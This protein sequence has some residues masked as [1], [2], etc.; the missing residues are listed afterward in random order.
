MPELKV[1][2]IVSIEYHDLATACGELLEWSTVES[3]GFSAKLLRR[4]SPVP[5]RNS[6][7]EIRNLPQSFTFVP[8]LKVVKIV[9]DGNHELA[10]GLGRAP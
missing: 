5:I 7:S 2:K 4:S 8:E 6:H 9:S 3:C 1:W 10:P